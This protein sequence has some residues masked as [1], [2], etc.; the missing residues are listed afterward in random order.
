MA[1]SGSVSPYCTANVDVNGY[2]YSFNISYGKRT[3]QQGAVD[4][5]WVSGSNT[6]VVPL[7]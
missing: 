7:V 1:G 2:T 6:T 5:A 3:E 4:V